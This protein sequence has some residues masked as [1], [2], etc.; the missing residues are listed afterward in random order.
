MGHGGSII[1]CA[2]L[3][4]GGKYPQGIW[5]FFVSARTK[6]RHHH[7]HAPA[8]SEVLFD[9]DDLGEYVVDLPFQWMLLLLLL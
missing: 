2:S 9:S 3:F 4:L 1:T 7:H 5:L 6:K 8:E